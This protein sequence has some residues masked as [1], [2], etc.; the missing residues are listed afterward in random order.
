MEAVYK[1]IDLFDAPVLV[2]REPANSQ[3]P[4]H[5]GGRRGWQSSQQCLDV[6]ATTSREAQGENCSSGTNQGPLTKLGDHVSAKQAKN[7]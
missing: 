2:N 7:H 6:A 4:V 1:K 5:K 3:G